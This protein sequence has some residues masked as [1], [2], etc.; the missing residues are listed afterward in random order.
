[1]TDTPDPSQDP[2]ATAAHDPAPVAAPVPAPT[3]EDTVWAVPAHLAPPA[4]RSRPW[5]RTALRWSIATVLCAA[6]GT[7]TAFAVMAPDRTDLPGLKTPADG[8]YVFPAFVLPPMPSAASDTE[9]TPSDGSHPLH[10]ADLRGLLLPV[11]V[12]GRLAAAY[13]GA[14]GWYPS[15]AYAAKFTTG[16]SLLTTFADRGLRHIAATAWTAPD[17]TRTEIYLLAFR[18]ETTASERVLQDTLNLRLAAAPKAVSD[19]T[20]VFPGLN[21]A[22]GVLI[23]PAGGAQPA[24]D[25][26]MVNEG[27]VEEVV[28]MSNPK[29]VSPTAFQQVMILQGEILQS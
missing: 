24:V 15:S 12:G 19:T 28:V 6:V 3:G 2:T 17:G 23:Q 21:T 13:P 25:L 10:T 5:L 18:S 22:P 8:R 9:N 14:H 7:G 4:R 16:A 1:M 20:T 29:A 27:D 26:G 11:P